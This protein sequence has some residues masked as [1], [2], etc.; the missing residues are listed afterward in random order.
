MEEVVD[1]NR[2]LAQRGGVPG[3]ANLVRAFLRISPDHPE[4]EDGVFE[5]FP[6][7]EVNAYSIHR[8]LFIDH[9]P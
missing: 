8:T 4:A 7:W 1:R 2:V 3:T 5:G 9:I 6:I